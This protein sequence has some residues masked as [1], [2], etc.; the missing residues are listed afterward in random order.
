[1]EFRNIAFMVLVAYYR[2]TGV[3]SS[4]VRTENVRIAQCRSSYELYARILR[5]PSRVTL[6][7]V[8]DWEGWMMWMNVE[9]PF[10]FMIGRQDDQ[11]NWLFVQVSERRNTLVLISESPP[12]DSV[13]ESD[14]R[15]FSHFVH[16]HTRQNVLKHVSTQRYVALSKTK[17]IMTNNEELAEH[18]CLHIVWTTSFEELGLRWKGVKKRRAIDRE[19]SNRSI[20]VSISETLSGLGIFVQKFIWFAKWK[21]LFNK[22]HKSTYRKTSYAN[23]RLNTIW[24]QQ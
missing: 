1:M 21:E 9:N 23:R 3:L 4:W 6:E 18:W 2:I 11:E 15:I 20:I 14:S 5:D 12:T 19:R 16:V 7:L 22:D 17:L 24:I 13:S 8:N 10:N